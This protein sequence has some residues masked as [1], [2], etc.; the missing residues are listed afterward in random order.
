MMWD[1]DSLYFG[2]VVWDDV[3]WP[4]K[5]PAQPWVDDCVFLYFD[6]NNDGTVDNKICFFLDDEEP[7]AMVLSGI[8]DESVRL[9]IE[10]PNNEALGEGGRFIEFSIYLDDLTNLEVNEGEFFGLQVG[11]EEGNDSNQDDGFKFICWHG[12]DPDNGANHLPVTF[13]GPVS[14]SQSTDDNIPSSYALLQNYPNPFNPTTT[15]TYSLEKT[16]N[17]T[18]DVYDLFGHKIRTLY[19]GMQTAGHHHVQWNGTNDA[20]QPV[21]TGVYLYRLHTANR[22]E[23]RKMMLLK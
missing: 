7:T 19:S 6:A 16:Q 23:T 11:V 8:T 2:A 22:I 14:V 1:N 9:A 13:G 3:Y 21:S 17:V 4:V 15:I 20:N 12:L 5:D 18:V 10:M